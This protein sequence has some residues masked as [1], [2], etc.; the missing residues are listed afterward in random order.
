MRFN[1]SLRHNEQG[2]LSINGQ[3]NTRHLP[4]KSFPLDRPKAF[5]LFEE[6]NRS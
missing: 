6:P 2:V 4:P 5:V 1:N 3:I